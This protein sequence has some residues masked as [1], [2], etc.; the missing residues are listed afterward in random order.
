MVHEEGHEVWSGLSVAERALWL[1]RAQSA[2][3]GMRDFLKQQ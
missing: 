2:V 3:Y 1:R